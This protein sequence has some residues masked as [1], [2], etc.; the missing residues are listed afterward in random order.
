[1]VKDSASIF[2]NQEVLLVSMHGK[3]AVLAPVLQEA[4]G[5]QLT[6]ATTINTDRFGTFSGE[7]DRPDTQHKTALLK[8]AAGFKEYPEHTWALAS[9]GAFVPHPEV[10]FLTLDY[11]LLVLRNK[12]TGLEISGQFVSSET[13]LDSLATSSSE[14]VAFFASQVGFPAHGIIMRPNSLL[15][16]TQPY[17]VKGINTESKLT[18]AFEQCKVLSADGKVY[19]E[20]DMRAMHNPTRLRNIEQAALELVKNMQCTCPFCTTPGFTRTQNIIGLPCEWC[21]QPTQ[22]VLAQVYTCRSCLHTEEKQYP[23]GKRYA[24]AGTCS[25][26]NP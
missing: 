17:Y 15:P 20:T 23:N 19:L 10:P 5:M 3:E 14:E 16:G 24:A 12:L 22:Q 25:F 6:V 2:R 7:I 9:E 26:C 4:F 18:E 21:H 13:N 11:E 8:L 1:M